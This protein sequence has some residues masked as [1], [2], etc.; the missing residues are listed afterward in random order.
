MTFPLCQR[1]TITAPAGLRE[2]KCF[3]EV[4]AFVRV[5]DEKPATAAGAL[6][7]PSFLDSTKFS[8]PF[9]LSATSDA[10]DSNAA[11]S[12]IL[13]NILLDIVIS[14]DGQTHQTQITNDKY[15][16]FHPLG[17]INCIAAGKND[18]IF[19]VGPYVAVYFKDYT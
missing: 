13:L 16:V 12:A 3:R 11:D 5:R 15:G 1:I 10:A 2:L 6:A 18:D 19:R 8:K 14:N 9:T 4:P 7:C 17:K